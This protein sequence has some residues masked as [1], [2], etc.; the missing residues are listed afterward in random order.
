[1][2]LIN[3]PTPL[4][5]PRLP[6][7]SNKKLSSVDAHSLIF[8]M[9]RLTTSNKPAD[10]GISEIFARNLQ[11]HENK[12]GFESFQADP[13]KAEIAGQLSQTGIDNRNQQQQNN[14]LQ[15]ANNHHPNTTVDKTMQDVTTLINSRPRSKSLP[16]RPAPSLLPPR[17]GAI[18]RQLHNQHHRR[19]P[20]SGKLLRC[21]YA[22]WAPTTSSTRLRGRIPHL[23]ITPP[24]PPPSPPPRYTNTTT[25]SGMRRKYPSGLGE[26]RR[27]DWSSMDDGG[28]SK[29]GCLDT[30]VEEKDDK[31]EGEEREENGQCKSQRQG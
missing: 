2:K 7:L 17:H 18:H 5:D 14:Q 11:L 12:T 22:P 27:V 23:T 6:F 10:D 1:M 8:N 16:P 25:P 24:S 4:I 31:K 29:A 20:K 15:E 9:S 30:I 28:A 13:S 19:D 3:I 26:R 21:H